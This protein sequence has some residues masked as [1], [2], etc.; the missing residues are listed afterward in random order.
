MDAGPALFRSGPQAV[1]LQFQLQISL[2]RK[3]MWG[4]MIHVIV[5]ANPDAPELWL[6][7]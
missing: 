1:P 2:F 4:I 3:T 5:D 6:S 7:T